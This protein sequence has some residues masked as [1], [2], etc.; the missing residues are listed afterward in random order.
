MRDVRID[1]LGFVGEL[2]KQLADDLKTEVKIAMSTKG[3]YRA[4]GDHFEAVLAPRP[5]HVADAA[6]WMSLY[7][8]GKI[9]RRQFLAAVRVSNESALEAISGE[10]LAKISRTIE[11]APALCVKRIKGV[12]PSLLKAIEQLST[13]VASKQPVPAL[14]NVE[15]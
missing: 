6:K 13:I 5:T 7:E 8:D 11:G 4:E 12:E 1:T 3:A 15:A 9:T 14:S 2:Q 10:Q